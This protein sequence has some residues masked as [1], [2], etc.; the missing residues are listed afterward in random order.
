[1]Y[2]T[3]EQLI[4]LIGQPNR[5]DTW[6]AAFDKFLNKYQI[7]TPIRF[8]MWFSQCAHESANFSMLKENLNYSA[9]ALRRVFGKYFPTGQLATAYAR[10]PAKIANRVYANRMGNGSEASGD[11]FKFCGR[12]L[13]QLTGKDN[14][15][16]FAKFCGKP[17]NEIPDY[18]QTE[19]GA[20]ESACWYWIVNNLNQHADKENVDAVSDII[21]R[22]HVT[23]A[24]G[25]ANGYRDRLKKYQ[26][27]LSIISGD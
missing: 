9:D 15:E 14:Y 18:L 11:G 8:A 22:G 2:L 3:K 21:N 26:T 27:V 20:V 13:I 25:D 17:L 7:D 10:Q 24:I 19:E 12:G 16:K 1:M 5:A 4:T 6:L 23:S